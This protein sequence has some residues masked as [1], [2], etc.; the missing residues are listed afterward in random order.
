MKIVVGLQNRLWK[1]GCCYSDD[2]A[3]NIWKC[4]LREKTRKS[5]LFMQSKITI[6]KCFYFCGKQFNTICD[7]IHRIMKHNLCTVISWANNYQL[8]L[9]AQFLL[10]LK[11][12]S[13]HPTRF[14][15][16]TYHSL[17]LKDA[18]IN[19]CKNK[20]EKCPSRIEK[21]CNTSMSIQQ[22]YSRNEIKFHEF[23]Y[24]LYRGKQTVLDL[25]S[26]NFYVLKY[27]LCSK[28]ESEKL[29]L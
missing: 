1:F 14:A 13:F 19:P 26:I 5:N 22:L 28:K 25:K 20:G 15:I 21:F 29:Q 7:V 9:W 24:P 6:W 4:S 2:I 11:F 16:L 23:H 8:G 27:L 12:T 3:I 17:Y 10:K 18:E